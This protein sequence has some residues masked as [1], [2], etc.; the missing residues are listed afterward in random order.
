MHYQTDR[1]DRYLILNHEANFFHEVDVNYLHRTHQTKGT[2]PSH[3]ERAH[4]YRQLGRPHLQMRR[5]EIMR[6]RLLNSFSQEY[7]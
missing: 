7:S 1:F 4:F 6:I 3:T 5:S 2:H